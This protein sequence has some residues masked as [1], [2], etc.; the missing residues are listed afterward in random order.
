MDFELFPKN[1]KKILESKNI[2]KYI[3]MYINIKTEIIN[4]NINRNIN[5]DV[6]KAYEKEPNILIIN[7]D[8]NEPILIKKIPR[9][10]IFINNIFYITPICYQQINGFTN[11]NNNKQYLINDFI[12]R[13]KR[14]FGGIISTPNFKFQN[15]TFINM[16][17]G[18]KNITFKN[19][20]KNWF[21]NKIP[22]WMTTNIEINNVGW[23]NAFNKIAIDYVFE[24]YNIN[25]IAELGTY[26]GLS[27]KYIAEKNKSATLY[28]F[29]LFNNILL[30]DY[31][32]KNITPLETKYFFKYI[33][34]ESFHSKLSDFDNLYSVKYNCYSS[35]ELL[36]KY[37]IKIDLFYIDFCKKDRLLIQFVDKIFSL[38]PECIIIG[39][40]ALFLSSSLEYFK[41]KYN[42]I[43][44]KDC[45]ICSYKTKLINVDKLLEKY[46]EENK[47][48]DTKDIELLK[49][50]DINYK[51]KYIVS[52][53]INKNKDVSEIIKYLEILNVNPNI[54]SHFLIHKSNIFHHIAYSS[55]KNHNYYNNLYDKLNKKYTDENILNNLNLTPSDYF[56][57]DLLSDF[58]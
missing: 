1:I 22:K 39:D 38:Y 53:L 16:D 10:P 55:I 26:Y 44:I 30:S 28:S 32:V 17:S 45:Y 33:K 57:Y 40:D 46:N 7:F 25:N 2:P 8:N 48:R 18:I 35:P 5:K 42:Y 56:K 27:T 15:I 43:Y 47:Y 29:D 34:F 14:I 51:I 12:E 13:I 36:K 50:I 11:D 24:N 20:E 21:V 52:E 37:N 4:Y 3:D 19:I 9:Y 54:K 58:S 6:I 31:I 49:N 23:F 41:N